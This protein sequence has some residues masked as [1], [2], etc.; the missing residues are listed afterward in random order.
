[1]GKKEPL[2]IGW[3]EWAG[4]PDLKVPLIKVKIDTGARTSALH[5]YNIEIIEIED[6][7]FAKFI[8]HP[9]QDNDQISVQTMA[10]IVDMRV[11]KSSNGHK[12]M[13]VVVNSAIQIGDYKANINITLTNRDIMNHR[14]L[15]GRSAMKNILINPSKSYY[16]GRVSKEQA[17]DTYNHIV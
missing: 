7:K 10:E 3:R 15:L 1:M 9:I 14:M 12:Q 2:L 13:R 16:L 8:I 4:L 6:K 11:I 5:A 17:L